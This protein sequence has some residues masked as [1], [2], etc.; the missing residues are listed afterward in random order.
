MDTAH[1]IQTIC[2]VCFEGTGQSRLAIPVM[3]TTGNLR[4]RAYLCQDCM[5]KAEDAEVAPVDIRCGDATEV[6]TTCN[7]WLER[8]A[9]TDDPVVNNSPPEIWETT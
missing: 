1:Y 2:G 7:P 8:L 9:T 5:A 3:V 4:I 6:S